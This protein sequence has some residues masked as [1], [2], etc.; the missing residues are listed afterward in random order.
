MQRSGQNC[1]HK[2][3]PFDSSQPGIQSLEFMGERLMVYAEEVK[4]GRVKIVNGNGIFNSSVAEVVCCSIS[5]ASFDSPTGQPNREA[6]IMMVP[7][8]RTFI[9]LGHGRATE[10]TGPNNERLIEQSTL[11]QVC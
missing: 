6:Q 4:H 10:F 2:F 8:W 3:G 9:G 1:P 5:N 11:A 7:A